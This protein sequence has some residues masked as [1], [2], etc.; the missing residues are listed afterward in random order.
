MAAAPSGHPSTTSPPL[1]P[2]PA[3]TPST[4]SLHDKPRPAPLRIASA[5]SPSAL[6]STS[7]GTTCN[8]PLPSAGTITPP[9]TPIATSTQSSPASAKSP[10]PTER[11]AAE[12]ETA[13][14]SELLEFPSHVLDYDLSG[15][16]LL[17]S[18][19]WSDVY[20]ARP[21]LPAPDAATDSPT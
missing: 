12:T 7:S 15:A 18:G 20:R 3:A 11:R 1:P 4:P 19:L 17:G 6:P 9:A 10:A 13:A 2:V 16:T 14:Q 21:C 8:Q 5:R